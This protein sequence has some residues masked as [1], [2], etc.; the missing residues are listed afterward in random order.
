VNAQF[1]PAPPPRRRPDPAYKPT[2]RPAPVRDGAR[3]FRRTL[4]DYAELMRLHR[5]IGTW[6]LMWPALWGLWFAGDGRPQPR[7]LLI[8][9]AGVLVMR[10][11][12]CVI[13][14]YADRDFDPHV[15]RT[16]GRPLAAGRVSPG[17]ALVLFVGLGLVAAGLALQLEPLAQLM[18]VGGAL[19]AVT[20][21]FVKRYLHVPQFYLG[22]AFAWSIP[23]AFAQLTGGVP[24]LAWLLV[25]AVVLW[26]AVYDTMYAMVDREDDLKIGLKS[27]AILFG[28]ADRVLVAT[29]QGMVLFALYLAG[30]EAGLGWWYQAG[31]AVGAVFFAYEQWLMRDREP[32]RCFQ[33][34]NNNHYF[35][36]VVFIGLALDYLYR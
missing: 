23:M 13:N 18:A 21:P 34:F 3:A 29:M 33:A 1:R 15:R 36:M 24:R 10:S 32:A 7:T 31:L 16:A 17:E 6:L 19:L 8:F 22:I 2:Y 30:S 11:A 14:D 12:G 27:T 28:D 35:G 26:A 4:T 25:V 20:Y 5:P 9:M